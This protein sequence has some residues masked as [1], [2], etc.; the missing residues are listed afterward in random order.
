MGSELLCYFDL[1]TC[2]KGE[3]SWH[4]KVLW[5]FCVFMFSSFSNSIDRPTPLTSP[6]SG[7]GAGAGSPGYR[8]ASSHSQLSKI[9]RQMFLI[10]QM[11]IQKLNEMFHIQ[12]QKK[13]IGQLRPLSDIQSVCIQKLCRVKLIL[14]LVIQLWHLRFKRFHSSICK[15]PLWSSPFIW[16]YRNERVYY[17]QG[18]KKIYKH[19]R[20]M[21]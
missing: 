7:L 11:F 4:L 6:R 16:W 21:C 13:Y 18:R 5:I 3:S 8:G 15:D 19:C 12:K 10:N 14:Q 17:F 1:W 20:S 9:G 2:S